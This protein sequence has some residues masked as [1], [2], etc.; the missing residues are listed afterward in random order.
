MGYKI[1]LGNWNSIFAVPSVITDKY[2][3]LATGNNLKVLLYFLRHAGENITADEISQASG[4]KKEEVCDAFLFWEQVGLFVETDGEFMLT[5]KQMSSDILRQEAKPVQQK[6]TEN[7]VNTSG[8]PIS[9]I[10]LR[11]IELERESRFNPKEIAEV[12]RGNSEVDYLFKECERLFGRPLKHN[13][14]N[15]LMII[16]EDAGLPV[17]CAL[18][19]VEYCSSIGKATPSYIK[20]IASDWISNGIDAIDRVE[21]EIKRLRAAYSIENEIKK[22]F[23]INTAL[24]KEQKQFVEKWTSTY[25]FSLEMIDEAYQITL[26]RTGK[27]S[28]AYMN[29]VITGWAENGVKNKEQLV[30]NGKRFKEKVLAGVESSFDLDDLTRAVM[31]K[32]S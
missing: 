32:Y 24:S 22:L 3:K 30:E 5:Q 13:E 9:T 25:G 11:K 6:F 21:A 29:K 26:N 23:E 27:L 17:S 2:L 18:M 8:T 10:S 4:V 20:S 7:A 1:N 31:E 15:S 16:V 14:Q 28:F 12:V 19:L